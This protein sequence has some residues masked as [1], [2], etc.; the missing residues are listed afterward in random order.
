MIGKL[1][2]LHFYCIFFSDALLE[3]IQF[4]ELQFEITVC[5]ARLQAHTIAHLVATVNDDLL[6]GNDEILSSEARGEMNRMKSGM[7]RAPLD[8]DK[9]ACKHSI[10]SEKPAQESFHW[11]EMQCASTRTSRSQTTDE[12]VEALLLNFQNGPDYESN[13]I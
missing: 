1:L 10:F 13:S 11:E 2:L 6:F 4:I 9:R 8:A 5:R 7:R 12:L 3:L